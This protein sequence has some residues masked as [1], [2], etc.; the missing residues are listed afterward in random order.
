MKLK[1]RE[2]SFFLVATAMLLVGEMNFGDPVQARTPVQNST[3][4]TSDTSQGKIARAM[5]A[6]PD[7]IARSA[8]IIDTD[9]EGN[10]VVL[11]E[12]S[13]GF[14][15]MPGNPEVIGE[16]PMCVDAASLQWFADAKAHNPNRPTP[17]RVS[18]TCSQALRR[19]AIRIL[20]TK[21]VRQSLWGRTG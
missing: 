14:T 20:M 16:P 12:G 7:D 15:C 5:S 1:K 19:G 18:L 21:P 3:T 6:G 4:E 13:N 17:S 9:A 11:R 8:R 10:T 2:L